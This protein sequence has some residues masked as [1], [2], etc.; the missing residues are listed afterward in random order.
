MLALVF[1]LAQE[2]VEQG[3]ALKKGL[4]HREIVCP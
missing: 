2:P 3:D 1:E 4:E